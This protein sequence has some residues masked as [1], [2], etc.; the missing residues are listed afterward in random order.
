MQ[1]K[2]RL[3]K[4]RVNGGGGRKN[5]KQHNART[6]MSTRSRGR[7]FHQHGRGNLSGKWELSPLPIHQGDAHAE[8]RQIAGVRLADCPPE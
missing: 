7:K 5:K 8:A 3:H 2:S 1:M 4:E 6:G